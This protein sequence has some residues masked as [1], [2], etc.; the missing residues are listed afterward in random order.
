MT[1]TATPEIGTP[2]F[3]L[4]CIE[5]REKEIR[6]Y[7]FNIDNYEM[8]IKYI[9][10]A[11]EVKQRQEDFL[12][13]LKILLSSERLEMERSQIMLNVLLKRDENNEDT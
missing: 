11:E 5:A 7:Q 6:G 13:K 4:F 2:E 8:A 10:D 1:E 9:E 12:A 3:I